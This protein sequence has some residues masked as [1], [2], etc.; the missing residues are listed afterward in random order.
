MYGKWP[1]VASLSA[2]L[3]FVVGKSLFGTESDDDI[4]AFHTRYPVKDACL[5][6]AA[7][8]M[9]PCTSPNC[10]QGVYLFLNRCLDQADGDKAQF[11]ENVGSYL[12]SQERDIFETHCKPH[13]D[14]VSECEKIIGYTGNYCSRIL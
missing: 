3:I 7:E 8:R 12:D 13:S 9:V 11:C 14:Y 5:G 6:A 4:A 10:Y 2:L 1:I